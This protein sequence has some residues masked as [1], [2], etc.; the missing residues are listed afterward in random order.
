MTTIKLAGRVA[1]VTLLAGIASGA[2]AALIDRGGGFIYD[3][4]LDITWTQNADLQ[5]QAPG[6]ADW[7]TQMLWAA[8]LSLY[9]SVRDVFWD[10]WRLP[11]MDVN[12]DTFVEDCSFVPEAQ[13]L[14]NEFGHLFYWDG[15]QTNFPGPFDFLD[16][17]YW[18]STEDLFNLNQAYFFRFLN[19]ANQQSTKGAK[20]LAWAVRDGDVGFPQVVPVPAAAWLF[21]GALGLL[22]LARRRSA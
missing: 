6:G 2:Q 20:R 9:D 4:V 18:S 8:N 21:G 1:T 7:E 5:G 22:G 3:D 13:C 16:V 17:N 12:G 10:D 11:S 15:V 19:G 14:D